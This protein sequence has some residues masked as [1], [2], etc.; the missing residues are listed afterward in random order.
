MVACVAALVC[1]FNIFLVENAAVGMHRDGHPSS[2]GKQLRPL[3]NSFLVV[4][5]YD[6]LYCY[7]R[8][9]NII[10]T[11]SVWPASLISVTCFLLL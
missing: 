8:Y 10:F 7:P 9:R 2:F 11:V 3:M 4:V 5:M 6:I 1:L